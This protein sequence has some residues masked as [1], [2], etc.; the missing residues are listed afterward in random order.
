MVING[1]LNMVVNG[2]LEIVI[3]AGLKVVFHERRELA[4][5]AARAKVEAARAKQARLE[6]LQTRLE[7]RLFLMLTIPNV[8]Y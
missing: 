4:E 7:V 3:N 1:G 5:T 6:E 8:N 2:G